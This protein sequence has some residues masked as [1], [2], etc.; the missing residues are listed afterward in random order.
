MLC[1]LNLPKTIPGRCRQYRPALGV[2]VEVAVIVAST[3]VS[4]G[5]VRLRGPFRFDGIGVRRT[6]VTSRHLRDPGVHH[7]WVHR[8]RARAVRVVNSMM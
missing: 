6:H 8:R 4:V 1:V 3:V 7:R 2:E 5:S